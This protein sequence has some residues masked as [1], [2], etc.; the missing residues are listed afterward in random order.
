MTKLPSV[1]LKNLLDELNNM[2]ILI[3]KWSLGSIW[4]GLLIS[5]L[6]DF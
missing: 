2:K 4:P 1:Q 3:S 6:S 5:W